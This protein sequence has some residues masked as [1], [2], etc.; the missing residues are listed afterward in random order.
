MSSARSTRRRLSIVSLLAVV[1][2]VLTGCMFQLP[3]DFLSLP[4]SSTSPPG[5]SDG[6][7]GELG[8]GKERFTEQTIDWQPCG[9]FECADIVAPM[10]W[11]DLQ[12][13]TISLRLAKQPATGS[14]KLGTLFVNPGGPGA[15]G[16]SFVEESIDYA[17][18]EDLQSQFDVIGWDPRGV[19]NSSSVFCYTD[20]EMDEMLYG[21]PREDTQYRRGTDEWI[22]AARTE[23]RE[24]GEDCLDGTG[25]LM[26][27]VD[28][29][30]T[31]YDLE[32]MR[33]LVGDEK[34]NYLGFSY[35][36]FI[37]ALYADAFADRVGRLVLD[38]ALAPDVTLHEVVLRQQ[39]G[40]ETATRAYLNECLSRSSCPFNGTVD[41]AMKEIGELIATVDANPMRASDGR[42]VSSG[43]FITAIILPLYNEDNWYL[44]DDLFVEV[45]QGIPET[46]LFLAD[47]YN[48][49]S[50]GVYED[51]STV[52]FS[53]INCLDYPPGGDVKQMRRD[54]LEIERAAPT[55]GKY[56]GYSDISC[57]EW[58]FAGPDER[59]PVTG[60][61][62]DPIL[63]IGTTGDPA[64]PY[65]WAEQLAEQLENGVLV[66]NNGE[67]HG[68]YTA[69]N[70][71]IDKTVEQYFLEG[72][73]PATDPNC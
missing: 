30:S 13:E 41:E 28:T 50:D 71:C 27:H 21:D 58:P 35:G 14:K 63:V 3:A 6:S 39:K 11:N 1:G 15:G 68:A 38:G 69:G 65:V 66:T 44:L 10:N 33:A 61:G 45:R 36:T 64:T 42:W 18:G 70:A 17:V 37:G 73:V 55:F 51:N 60:A 62:A 46:A 32:M 12:G 49:R 48:G 29:L 56:A 24:Y 31:V 22:E 23:A 59:G 19:G 72:K 40:F 43:T 8:E 57:Q 9:E 47:F 52:A 20:E 53:A 16:A 7:P 4:E 25:E 54:A 5:P 67:G 2:V 26:A 34:L